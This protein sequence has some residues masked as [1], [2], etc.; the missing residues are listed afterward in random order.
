MGSK[1]EVTRAELNEVTGK[2]N[3]TIANRL[4][5]LMDRNLV[6]RNGNRYDSNQTYSLVV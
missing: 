6:K 2:S 1:A 5:K 4:N 3:A